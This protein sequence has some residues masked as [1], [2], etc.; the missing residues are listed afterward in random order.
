MAQASRSTLFFARRISFTLVPLYSDTLDLTLAIA[1]ASLENA[2]RV[3]LFSDRFDL[4][5]RN[6]HVCTTR[7]SR[8]NEK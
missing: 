3:A 5:K 7:R 1:R 2:A 6:L 8:V 4:A